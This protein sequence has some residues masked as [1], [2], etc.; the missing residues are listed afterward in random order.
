MEDNNA[1]NTDTLF[2]Y[3]YI[4]IVNLSIKYLQLN[5]TSHKPQIIIILNNF[6]RGIIL[7]NHAHLFSY[8]L[9]G[10]LV[11]FCFYLM[12]LSVK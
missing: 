11:G 6:V 12:H 3:K 10:D 2:I 4:H 5:I 8:E 7:I 9:E 1:T